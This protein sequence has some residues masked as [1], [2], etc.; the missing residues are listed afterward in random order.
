MMQVTNVCTVEQSVITPYFLQKRTAQWAQEPTLRHYTVKSPRLQLHC[1]EK[2][3]YAILFWE[4]R[5]LRIFGP[6]NWLQQNRQT[7]LSQIYKCSYWETE[8][9]NSVLEIRYGGCTVSFLGIR[10]RYQ[11]FI[12]DDYHRPFICSVL[13]QSFSCLLFL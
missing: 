11:T 3:I 13:G 6:H 10:K 2:P 9:Y 5:G 8:H 4:M 12:L 7:N 1:N